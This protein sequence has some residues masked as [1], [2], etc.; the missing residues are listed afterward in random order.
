M[1]K[2]PIVTAHKIAEGVKIASLTEANE[3]SDQTLGRVEAASTDDQLRAVE[4]RIHT[5]DCTPLAVETR[6]QN[7]YHTA[8]AVQL[9]I[10][11]TD[12][13]PLAVET[14]IHTTHNKIV[15]LVHNQDGTMTATMACVDDPDVG[16]ADETSSTKRKP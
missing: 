9:R 15:K 16:V 10:V 2:K 1:R 11:N 6:I 14:R 4:T 5:T 12:C 7:I 8:P 3:D 13:T